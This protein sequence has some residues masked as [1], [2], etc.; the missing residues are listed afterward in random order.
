MSNID[1]A[2]DRTALSEPRSTRSLRI[3]YIP[4]IRITNAAALLQS[5][6][7]S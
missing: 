7:T 5:Y 4:A 3:T 2:V 6:A 1:R